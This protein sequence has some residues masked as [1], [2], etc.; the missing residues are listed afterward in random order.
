MGVLSVKDCRAAGQDRWLHHFEAPDDVEWS[1][2]AE[3]GQ[4]LAEFAG[5]A[6]YQSWTK[7]NPATATNAGYLAHI[8]EVGH[9][10]VLEHGTV[11]LLPDRGVPLVHPRADPA[12]A[13]LVLPA[14]PAVRAR[15]DAAMVEPEVI[16]D[17]PRAARVVRRGD[18]GERHG[19][20]RA[21]GRAWSER[22]A[23]RAAQDASDAAAQAGPAGGAGGAAQRD[24]DP[25]R[26]HR[27]LPGLAAL[28]RDAGHRARR[29]RDPRELPLRACGSCSGSRRM[30]SP[31]SPSPRC[32]T[33]PRS[34]RVS[35][36][37]SP[38]ADCA[39]E[40]HPRCAWHARLFAMTRTA[41]DPS[42]GRSAGWSP[43]WSP[44]SRG[45]LARPRRRGAARDLPRRRA[46]QRRPGGQRHH[47]RVADHHRRG[48]GACCSA[49]V[50]EAVGDRAK[51]IAG[52]RHQRHPAHHRAGAVGGEG[53]GAT[54]CSW[55]RRTT[56]SRRRPACCRALHCGRRRPRPAGHALRHPAPVRDPDRDRDHGPARRAR[57]DR[58]GQGRQGRPGRRP[59][60][61]T[62]PDRPGLLLR[63]RQEHPAAAGR[64]RGRRGRRRRPTLFGTLEPRR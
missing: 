50:V 1:T 14:V 40:E 59:R 27:Q 12:P 13:L 51:V 46:G 49:A 6:C 44:R 39:P 31:T 8:L 58:R 41:D 15:A 54:A 25:D 22:F 5:R 29:R 48:E 2:D 33:A 47:R 24:R 55:S 43:R 16:A 57:A 36:H 21:A 42:A 38:E 61:V 63:R 9:L 45:R 62:A 26:G 3:G 7:P 30:S 37:G 23:G 35:S 4:A 60:W 34:R 53:R 18:R 32:R 64:R 17:D 19:V 52:R 28:H 11:D 10:S 20:H 56:T